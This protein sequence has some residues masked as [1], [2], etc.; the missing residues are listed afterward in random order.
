MKRS[1]L[2][3]KELSYL[4]FAGCMTL[5]FLVLAGTFLAGLFLRDWL[6]GL[7]KKRKK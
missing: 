7:S 2:I 1:L 6:L 3:L 5:V 4:L